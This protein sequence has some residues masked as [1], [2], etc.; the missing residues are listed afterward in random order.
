MMLVCLLNYQNV[1]DKEHSSQLLIYDISNFFDK[2]AQSPIAF[3]VAIS[4]N[5]Q[6]T[7]LDT[8]RV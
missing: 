3:F 8:L 4:L 2:Q 7:I 1:V 6:M 5:M